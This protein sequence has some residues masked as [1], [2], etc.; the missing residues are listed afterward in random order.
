[1]AGTP[2][3]TLT[4]QFDENK[5]SNSLA[6]AIQK[7]LSK[8]F[9]SSG[10]GGFNLN[11]RQFSPVLG[12]MT[13]GVKDF[14][15]VL[16]S[17]NKR[18]IGFGVSLGLIGGAVKAFREVVQATLDVDRTMSH[19]NSVM[20]LGV[21]QSNALQ[22]SLFDTAR[23][24][25]QSFKEAAAAFEAF[26]RQG[27]TAAQVADRTR[28]ALQLAKV[29]AVEVTE[30]VK[31]LTSANIAYAKS[32][33]DYASI[34]NKISAATRTFPGSVK[35]SIDA[36]SRYGAQA[37]ASGISLNKL[38]GIVSALNA[39]T[40]RSGG[41]IATSLSQLTYRLSQTSN[42][43]KLSDIIDTKDLNGQ[44]RPAL[45]LLDELAAKYRNLSQAQKLVVNQVVGGRGS[46]ANSS[47]ALLNDLSNPNGI[48]AN[49]SRA[50]ASAGSDLAARSAI[51]INNIAQAIDNLK[52]SAQQAGST[53]GNL[54]LKSGLGGL[55]NGGQAG[56]GIINALN[57][58]GT[59]K[60]GE[61]FGKYIGESILKGIGNVL[62]GPGLVIAS[63]V[64]F[65][66]A[67]R[68]F[69]E[70][71]TDF[72]QSAGFGPKPTS[73]GESD[74]AVQNGINRALALATQ[75]ER[76][77]FQAAT[78]TT[79]QQQILLQVLERQAQ[80]LAS[81][82][83]FLGSLNTAEREAFAIGG[84]RGAADGYLPAMHA[85]RSAIG[86]GVGGAPSS[87]RP[88]LIR[89]FA[90][91]G[92][93]VGP[94]VANTSEYMVKGSGGSAIYNQSMIQRFGLPPGATPVAAGGYVPNAAVGDQG[95]YAR[96]TKPFIP[97]SLSVPTT[98]VNRLQEPSE[99]Q[100]PESQINAL[101]KLFEGV[102]SAVSGPAASAFADDI[103][104]FANNLDGLSKKKVLGSLN[105]EL[106]TFSARLT[107]FDDQQ[108]Q[109]SATRIQGFGA[110]NKELARTSIPSFDQ[111]FNEEASRQ[112]A[113]KA[114]EIQHAFAQAESQSSSSKLYGNQVNNEIKS[115]LAAMEQARI[116]ASIK[117]QLQ[118]PTFVSH[119]SAPGAYSAYEA[120]RNARDA[121]LPGGPGYVNGLPPT[122]RAAS[123]VRSLA[124]ALAADR[125]LE[126]GAQRT[127]LA[128][129]DRQPSILASLRGGGSP[130]F[131]RFAGGL[132][133]GL[134][135]GSFLT[136]FL[137]EGRTS[138]ALQNGF[139]IGGA[140]S[141]AGDAVGGPV[142]GAAAGVLAGGV[143]AIY[144]YIK[145][146]KQSFDDLAKSLQDANAA[147]D[148]LTRGVSSYVQGITDIQNAAR[149]GA[150]GDVIYRLQAQ[151]QRTLASLPS[152]VK[153]QLLAAGNNP[154][155]LNAILANTIGGNAPGQAQRNAL[156]LTGAFA[157]SPSD[158][159]RLEAVQS[160]AGL[161]STGGRN[162]FR[163]NGA[164]L[165]QD[166]LLGK[167]KSTLTS[168]AGFSADN[169]NSA[170]EQL[171]KLDV[172]DLFKF[173]NE[174]ADAFDTNKSLSGITAKVQQDAFNLGKFREALD[175]E[176]QNAQTALDNTQGLSRFIAEATS[177]RVSAATSILGNGRIGAGGRIG[178]A[179]RS[180]DAFDIRA[181]YELSNAAS[182]VS[183][184]NQRAIVAARQGFRGAL[185]GS[186]DVL[187]DPKGL[188]TRINSATTPEVFTE[189]AKD[190]PAAFDKKADEI[191][192]K[193]ETQIA[194]NN[195]QLAAAKDSVTV[196]RLELQATQQAQLLSRGVFNSSN[197]SAYSSLGIATTSTSGPFGGLNSVNAR[198]Q[199]S[200]LLDRL[201]LLPGD[202]TADLQYNL[203]RQS[204]YGT[205][206]NLTS[207]AL[208]RRVGGFS[209]DISVAA[210]Q[211]IATG[212]ESNVELGQ[213]T[214][215]SIDNL[216]N[217]DPR[218][219]SQNLLS[220]PGKLGLSDLTAL[221]QTGK[222]SLGEGGLL[223]AANTTNDI[224][225]DIYTALSGKPYVPSPD[226]AGLQTAANATSVALTHKYAA[227][228][229]DVDT[230]YSGTKPN[231]A[232][233]PL[234]AF[235]GGL[236]DQFTQIGEAAKDFRDIG[237]ETANILDESFSRFWGNFVTGA[238][239]GRDAFRQFASSIFADTSKAFGTS[240]I[241]QIVG[242][243]G[244]PESH[245]RGGFVGLAAGGYVPA[246]LTGGE[247]VVG[248][249]AARRLGP[250]ALH[251]LN[252]GGT[253]GYA[254]GG[255]VRGGSGLRDDVPAHLPQGS[256][257]IKRSAVQRLGPN[258][259]SAMAGGSYVNRDAGGFIGGVGG[260][261]LF[262]GLAGALL[263]A[264]LDKKNRAQGALIGAGL[265]AGLGLLGG[266]LTGGTLNSVLGTNFGGSSP[267]SSGLNEF[268]VPDS[269]A[270]SLGFS[271]GASPVGNSGIDSLI[272]RQLGT[273]LALAGASAGLGYAL[274]PST[275]TL[276][277][278]GVMRNA[279]K[280]EADDAGY[281][282]NRPAG[283]F[284]N[285]IRGSNGTYNVIGFNGPASEYSYSS[286]GGRAPGYS[287]GGFVGLD[288]TTPQS[289]PVS[290]PPVQANITIH[291]Y[292][293][294]NVTS[295]V[296]TNNQ[297]PASLYGNQQFAERISK[298]VKNEVQSQLVE[299]QRQ[300]GS[301]S[302]NRRYL[303][304]N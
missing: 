41:N 148:S 238:A 286:S 173:L 198:L 133:K 282:A 231:Q 223:T 142:V 35:D 95:D 18:V 184:N 226:L 140:A 289:S 215:A 298:A 259:L 15:S 127:E 58:A 159:A 237:K 199:Q 81:R 34:A 26:S 268:N 248:P 46:Q 234:S 156:G 283:T 93:N 302:I 3:T 14:N 134:V 120:A 99:R 222:L 250:S 132:Q 128:A 82:G 205:L 152:G 6:S 189:L 217:F 111:V 135:A 265:G 129:L 253:M 118:N 37:E 304:S 294:G 254:D 53:V 221:T 2:T 30:V 67:K 285:I 207:R 146:A 264:I 27:G 232:P 114:A 151:N 272:S 274:S 210:K 143:A 28:I 71:I 110:A 150:S 280:V 154:D 295:S 192:K 1:M 291:N 70:V 299:A 98:Y 170:V 201:G 32:G 139:N 287:D 200:Q 47:I 168:Q 102:A 227:D 235:G 216:S 130:G 68:T 8:G 153:T 23:Q 263:G 45:Q 242:A 195:L 255:L 11:D 90:F 303:Q 61:D 197:L 144:T 42:I 175:S 177:R 103:T 12:R 230:V 275:K 145:G 260:L 104:S 31:G 191:I 9:S 233:S 187:D 262:G 122:P 24:T 48:S 251:A 112:A 62:S 157:N 72:K 108:K 63:R 54:S 290:A 64:L 160:I 51:Q 211:L 29:G 256:F 113:I 176:I 243:F 249:S 188:Q 261:G 74:L 101:N 209:G 115:G 224:L 119:Q 40:A 10:G 19:L 131:N 73:L 165:N 94:I 181:Q 4:A 164:F 97:G 78:K 284:S 49:V 65:G 79:E 158:A 59:T 125:L 92:G 247:Y 257:V 194:Q 241:N 169:A 206:Q 300:G 163:T 203:S 116:D 66:A 212:T 239:K 297:D 219:V 56:L 279:T 105:A 57:P 121:A 44:V 196:Q 225:K 149:S 5:L 172:G 147:A 208:G 36:V 162:P 60:A 137:P 107:N 13:A 292:G 43:T 33:E 269:T 174:L 202:R 7:G 89:N 17:A 220:N 267:V 178:G 229:S 124:D 69:G 96:I 52:T 281:I 138:N 84:I 213:R 166:A 245:A 38:L 155:A 80:V 100:I 87:A 278:P 190:F 273:K 136:P 246:M 16:D 236:R 171:S 271:G 126:E 106:S 83:A 214:L 88:V 204:T 50:V 76:E 86:A 21:T 91:G 266:A 167:F 193:M 39:A 277:T 183:L 179:G 186:A 296:S 288:T 123:Q 180:L 55:V 161:T 185:S 22:K 293:N 301:A 85:E 77:R 182:E 252:N 25:G 75:E 258:Y 244:S 218:K 228:R 117:R 20:A 141:F 240:A 276:D 270:V 109:E